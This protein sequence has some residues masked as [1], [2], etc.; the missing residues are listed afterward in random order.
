MPSPPS[1]NYDLRGRAARPR[2]P[3]SVSTLTPAQLD[4]KRAQD[5][6][7]QR[8]TRARTRDHISRLER[9]IHQL[10]V[11]MAAESSG[12]DTRI[13]E[14]LHLRNQALAEEVARLQQLAAT[15][16]AP[17]YRY[18]PV[19][20]EPD[21]TQALQ[22]PP[23]EWLGIQIP[24]Q[25]HS[26]LHTELHSP[27][28]CACRALDYALPTEHSAEPEAPRQG[29]HMDPIAVE[30]QPGW[31]ASESWTND[32]LSFG[33]DSGSTASQT[34]QHHRGSDDVDVQQQPASWHAPTCQGHC[35]GQ[36]GGDF[37]SPDEL[38]HVGLGLSWE[39]V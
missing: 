15:E 35:N 29:N 13:L 5:R 33:V 39:G 31:I 16:P 26:Q 27:G 20:Q 7:S 14:E 37:L 8:A 11:T 36:P 10:R 1:A 19:E 24:S 30:R 17:A 34:S 12:F 21:P 32:M 2:V 4:R 25:S 38:E 28:A 6:L 18:V 23:A 3:R 9:E 22:S